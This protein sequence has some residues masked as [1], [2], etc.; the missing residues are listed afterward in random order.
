MQYRASFVLQIFGNFIISFAELFAL[1]IMFQHFHELGGWNV[2]EVV[3][4]YGLSATMFGLAQMR[5]RG[6]GGFSAQVKLGEFDRILTRPLSAFLQASVS[7]FSVRYLGQ[8]LQGLLLLGYAVVAL[9]VRWTGAKDLL[10]VLRIV[11]G[12][13]VFISLFAI[14]AILCFWTVESTEAV[15]A[16]TY[17]GSDLAQ[18]PLN[19]FDQWLRRLFL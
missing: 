11:S 1:V 17:G 2:R 4:L 19:I 6:W 12:V 9:D 18:Y 13:A 7:D 3:F 16:F 5:G 14:E 10:L 8:L 15:N